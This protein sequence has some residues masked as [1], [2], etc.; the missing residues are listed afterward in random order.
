MQEEYIE[1]LTMAFELQRNDQIAQQQKAYLKDKFEFFGLK[2]PIRREVQKPFLQ[3]EYLPKKDQAFK[4]A[5]ELWKKPER[6]FHYFAQELISK[7]KN[8]LEE[9]DLDFIE[10]LIKHNSWWDTVDMIASHLVGSYFKKFP[11]NMS[12]LMLKWSVDEN[13]W[14]RRSSIIFQLKYRDSTDFELLSQVIENNLGSK[15]F[16]INKAIG[17]ALRTYSSVDPEKVIDF[18]ETHPTLS[19]LSKKEALRLIG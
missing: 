8:K 16:F 2:T 13:M 17:W 18:V 6:E 3:K 19:N 9:K 10:Y 15:E 1:N 4:I 14:I 7:Y 12:A 11:K 5:K